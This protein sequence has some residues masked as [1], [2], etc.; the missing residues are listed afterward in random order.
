MAD[1]NGDRP[2]SRREFNQVIE[3]LRELMA[4]TQEAATLRA[5]S[6]D[7]ARELQAKEYERRLTALNH[8]AARII[9]A[10]EKAVL[11]DVFEPWQAMVNE[12]ITE[13]RTVIDTTTQESVVGARTMSLVISGV[14]VIISIIAVIVAVWGG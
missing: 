5:E 11:R 8:E 4:N 1:V 7:K 12:F 13:R 14:G 3:H 6:L 9:T 2:V 10:A